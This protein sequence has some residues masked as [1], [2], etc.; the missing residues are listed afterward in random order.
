MRKYG[1][2][3]I[4]LDGC[5]SQV[6]M[7]LYDELIKATPAQS[8]RDPIMVENCHWGDKEPFKPNA[9][10]CPWN[11]YRTSHDL[12]AR[13]ASVVGN[14]KTTDYYATNNLSY[15]G[16]WAYADMVRLSLSTPPIL[17]PCVSPASPD[18]C[19][20]CRTARS[21]RL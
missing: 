3:G 8:G 2:D 20:T 4:K 10:W 13:Y 21:G 16:C 7:Q 12:R 14:L 15:P 1:F 11:M 17:L 9:T 5:G 19:V 6:D 18:A